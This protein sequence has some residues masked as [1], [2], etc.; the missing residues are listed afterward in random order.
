MDDGRH[1]VMLIC[2]LD[3][4]ED[5]NTFEDSEVG[6]RVSKEVVYVKNVGCCRGKGM[7]NVFPTSFCRAESLKCV[8]ESE[9]SKGDTCNSC[10]LSLFI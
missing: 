2:L 10:R 9:G 5:M 3:G 8:A 7:F 6:R 4:C 1:D